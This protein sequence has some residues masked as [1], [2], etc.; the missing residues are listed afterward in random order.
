MIV[1]EKF[2]ADTIPP[3][4]LATV[5]LSSRYLNIIVAAH[6]RL[7]NVLTSNSAFFIFAVLVV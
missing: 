2:L 4:A 6:R 5:L 7:I 3:A 1:Q